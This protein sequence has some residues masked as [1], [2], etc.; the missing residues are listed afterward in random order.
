MTDPAALPV[1]ELLDRMKAGVLSPVEVTQDALKR[2]EAIN[3]T[4]AAFV[5]LDPEGALEAARES[6]RRY[7]SGQPRPLDGVPFPVKD[8]EDTKGLRTTYGSR[9]YADHVPAQDNVTVTALRDAGA[10]IIG[11]TTT[12][13]FAHR[14]D[15]SGVGPAARHPDDPVRSSGGSSGG[16]ATAVAAGVCRV[17]HGSDGAGSVRLPAALC[18]IVGFKPTYGRI[19]RWPSSDAWA[20]R[21]HHGVLGRTVD[22]VALAMTGLARLDYRDP[23]TCWD[24]PE[25]AAVQPTD[26]PDRLSVAFALPDG[27]VDAEVAE[28]IRAAVDQLRAAG[29]RVDE[30]D[31]GLG[32]QAELFDRICTA[33]LAWD[34]RGVDR[35]D[36]RV[37][38]SLVSMIQ[39]GEHLDLTEYLQAREQ[40]GRL[41]HQVVSAL[42]GYDFLLTGTVPF[43]SWPVAER[44]AVNGRVLPNSVSERLDQLLI[45]NLLGWPAVSVPCGRT[46]RPSGWAGLQVVA[47]RGADIGCLQLASW[48]ERTLAVPR[49]PGGDLVG[50]EQ[51]ETS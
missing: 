35:H 49:D 10:I 24:Q 26:R 30:I 1:R 47:R 33:N 3:D 14:L 22:D 44:P 13:P 2:A 8:T 19:P 11:K 12:S 46:A 45:F 15:T 28:A 40:R 25:W 20:A 48:V 39:Y 6:E 50:A 38:N 21:S 42:D 27:E 37:E 43:E 17:A 7:R 29:L 9:L 23:L 41:N 16:A 51:H 31:L 32:S 34:L 5:T 36:E 4:L 18:G